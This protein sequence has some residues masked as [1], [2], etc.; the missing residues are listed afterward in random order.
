GGLSI[1]VIGGLGLAGLGALMALTQGAFWLNVVAGNANPFDLGQL[2]SYL[3]NFSVLHCVLLAMAAAECAWML[4]RRDWSPWAL[5][6]ITAG[7]APLSVAKWG[8]GESYFLG[9]IAA[10]SVLS[11][12]WV[13]RFLDS[14]PAISLRWG[15]GIAVFIQ[16]VLLSHAGLSDALPWLPDR[17]PQ[18]AQLV[19]APTAEDAQ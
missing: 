14:A 9:A 4:R 19:R 10:I 11:A 6:A 2:Q 13:A 3:T 18:G 8:A 1:A 17:G 7:L 5:Y 12:V 15:L 16:A